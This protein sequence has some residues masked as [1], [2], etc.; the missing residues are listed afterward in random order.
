MSEELLSSKLGPVVFKI[1]LEQQKI[2]DIFHLLKKYFRRLP[3]NEDGQEAATSELGQAL[4]DTGLVNSAGKDRF[5]ELTTQTKD[6]TTFQ[7]FVGF[8]VSEY[9]LEQKS[10]ESG[11][12]K[13]VV[14][15][16]D[17]IQISEEL[18]SELAPIAFRIAARVDEMTRIFGLFQEMFAIF[19]VNKNGVIERTEM[20]KLVE[21]N[22]LTREDLEKIDQEPGGGTQIAFKTFL[23]IWLKKYVE[24]DQ[25][26]E[27]V[28]K[29]K[30]G[31]IVFKIALAQQTISSGFALLRK[32]YNAFDTKTKGLV[33]KEEIAALGIVSP[34]RLAAWPTATEGSLT[35]VEFGAFYASEFALGEFDS[36]VEK[37]S[38]DVSL[39]L[40]QKLA[41]Q[42]IRLSARTEE[43][44]RIF[45]LFK[46]LFD[47]FDADNDGKINKKELA[48]LKEADFLKQTELDTLGEGALEYSDF[49]AFWVGHYL[50][51]VDEQEEKEK[52]K[53]LTAKEKE[54]FPRLFRLDCQ[55][56]NV[57]KIFQLL[58]EIFDILDENKTGYVAKSQ[59]LKM[60]KN[61]FLEG[62][63]LPTLAGFK[64]QKE[65]HFTFGEY[66]LWIAESQT[67]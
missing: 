23:G 5:G 14:N 59:V 62:A 64:V 10:R 26:E 63:G 42:L 3:S 51:E 50:E 57:T 37:K 44:K 20:D 17:S 6:Q 67:T 4:I 16:T 54:L 65:D 22:L 56:E 40:A 30:L 43:L 34:D 35:F 53:E 2:A 19:D 45:G 66:L 12:P 48:K 60:V 7:E 41:P 27:T 36:T 18:H 49:M 9:T 25:E 11:S 13:P 52:G 61:G 55:K 29:S 1:V 47:V 46:D 58:K 21:A 33:L 39:E 38:T 15:T 28:L 32:I 8:M 31:P 24:E